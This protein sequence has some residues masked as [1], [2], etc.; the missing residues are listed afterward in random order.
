MHREKPSRVSNSMF[1]GSFFFKG[2]STNFCLSTK[3]CPWS[4]SPWISLTQLNTQLCKAG[5]TDFGKLAF[6]PPSWLL[7]SHWAST[8]K[9]NSGHCLW[10]LCVGWAEVLWK[11]CWNLELD[12]LLGCEHCILPPVSGEMFTAKSWQQQWHNRTGRGSHTE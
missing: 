12:L 3:C 6:G 4:G 5:E 9:S 2:I 1:T 7:A 11:E 10:L 8:R